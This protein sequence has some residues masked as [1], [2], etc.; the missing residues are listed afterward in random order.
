MPRGPIG[1]ILAPKDEKHTFKELRG[2]PLGAPSD[3]FALVI[4]V[5]KAH[6][7]FSC[8]FSRKMQCAIRPR[9]CSLNDAFARS[10]PPFRVPVGT[11]FWAQNEIWMKKRASMG[12]LSLAR[13]QARL[14]VCFFLI[15]VPFAEAKMYRIYT[16]VCRISVS[17]KRRKESQNDTKRAPFFRPVAPRWLPFGSLDLRNGCPEGFQKTTK[18]ESKKQIIE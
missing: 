4:T 9:L 1:S 6:S 2:P 12:W 7:R 11:P 16:T 14:E 5:E 10:S 13:C 3:A 8:I 15:S 18:K 17:P